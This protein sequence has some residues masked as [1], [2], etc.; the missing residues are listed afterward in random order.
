MG[1]QQSPI[2]PQYLL[3]NIINIVIIGLISRKT[4]KVNL[5][6]NLLLKVKTFNDYKVLCNIKP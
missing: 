6:R 5:K 1:K 2:V 4:L 3:L